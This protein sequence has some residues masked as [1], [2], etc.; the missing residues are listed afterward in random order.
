MTHE[1]PVQRS[2][3]RVGHQPR[4]MRQQ[5]QLHRDLRHPNDEI[6]TDCAQMAAL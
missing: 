6:R 4:L 2:R 1:Q 5:G 3:D